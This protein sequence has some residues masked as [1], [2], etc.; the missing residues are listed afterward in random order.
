MNIHEGKIN[1]VCARGETMVENKHF[2]LLDIQDKIGQLRKR[3]QN[4]H[5]LAAA[6]K[7]DLEDAIQI[8]QFFTNAA[9]IEVGKMLRIK[10]Y[11]VSL[12]L[13]KFVLNFM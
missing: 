2:A 7:A 12:M 5:A 3:W 6:R 9:D 10:S 1:D 11:W 4:L 8:H 13:G